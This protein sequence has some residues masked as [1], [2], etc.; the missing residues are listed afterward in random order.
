MRYYVMPSN[1]I[2]DNL[3]TEEYLMDTADVSEPLLL[4]DEIK[5]LMKKLI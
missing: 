5:M 1:D 3:A 2:R 4:L